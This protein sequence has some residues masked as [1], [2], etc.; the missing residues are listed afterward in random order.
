MLL[1]GK[2]ALG[3]GA[4]LAMTTA[5]VFHEGVIRVDV[6]ENRP[7]GEHVHFWVPATSISAGMRLA[8]FV[9]QHPLD[10]AGREVRPYLPM[11]R[12]LPKELKKYPNAEFVD[13]ESDTDHVRVAT[14][15]GKI[16]IDANQDESKVHLSVPIET[17]GDVVD[18]LE[19][20]AR[21]WD[22]G[23]DKSGWRDKHKWRAA[24]SQPII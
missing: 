6:D 16:Q 21:S 3:M 5:Y 9:P 20:A 10:Q 12:K 1:L 13:V 24:S 8:R 14:V 4:T 15:N 11:L 18:R 19:D 2:I 17:L 22:E 23:P 7:G